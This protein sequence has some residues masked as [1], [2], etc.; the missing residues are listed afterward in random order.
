MGVETWPS[1]PGSYSGIFSLEFRPMQ[2]SPALNPKTKPGKDLLFS[3]P[4]V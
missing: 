2:E 4:T 3:V 1:N